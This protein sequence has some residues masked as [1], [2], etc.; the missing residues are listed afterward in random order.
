MDPSISSTELNK[1]AFSFETSE[2]NRVMIDEFFFFF[3][4]FLY[5]STVF[6][7]LSFCCCLFCWF[8]F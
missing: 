1:T 8:V 4:I 5:F 6:V 7:L 2:L 3:Y